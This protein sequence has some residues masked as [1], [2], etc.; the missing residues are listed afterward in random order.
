MLDHLDTKTADDSAAIASAN[1]AMIL[2]CSLLRP[3]CI[4]NVFSF[5]RRLKVRPH[6]FRQENTKKLRTQ[7]TKQ[8]SI[9]WWTIFIWCFYCTR[10]RT[11]RQNP[12]RSTDCGWSTDGNADDDMTRGWD[13][14]FSFFTSRFYK[15]SADSFYFLEKVREHLNLRMQRDDEK[16][17]EQRRWLNN[18][19]RK[20]YPHF[21]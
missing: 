16:E 19:D 14:W 8:K 13:E 7:L 18:A 3:L 1:Q 4:G 5:F 6:A 15:T 17:R 11:A 20:G 21:A 9:K 12:K 10:S 2:F